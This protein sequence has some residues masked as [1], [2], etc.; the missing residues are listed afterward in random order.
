MPDVSVAVAT[1]TG[2]V[3]RHPA[4]G[5]AGQLLD[6]MGTSLPF[7]AT[8]PDRGDPRPSIV[9]RYRDR[10]DYVEQARQAAQQLANEGYI[11]AEDVDLAVDLAV[12]RYEIL[13]RSP[14]GAA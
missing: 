7:A 9:Q 2:W 12:K 5:G 3:P 4:T 11:V 8:E 13:A 1:H 14:V 6:M 10:D